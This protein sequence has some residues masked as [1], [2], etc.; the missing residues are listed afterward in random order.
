MSSNS[1]QCYNPRS[2]KRLDAGFVLCVAM[3]R[4]V[5]AQRGQPQ[6][7]SQPPQRLAEAPAKAADDQ[8]ISVNVD[9]VIILFTVGDT[10]GKFVTNLRKDDFRVLGDEKA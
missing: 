5:A 7:K 8:T 10:K 2:M 6:Q 9:L 3:S 4:F 1:A